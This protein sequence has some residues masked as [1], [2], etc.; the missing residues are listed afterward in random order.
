M[1]SFAN[2]SLATTFFQWM[3]NYNQIATYLTGQNFSTDLA[4]QSTL[5]IATANSVNSVYAYSVANR[6]IAGSAF[7]RAN[8]VYDSSN[9]VSSLATTAYGQANTALAN[10]DAAGLVA[11]GAF[12]AANV[13]QSSVGA[14]Y[15]AANTSQSTAV[16]A[17]GA[18]NTA[19]AT[20]VAA[21]GAAN[22]AQS[23]A[24]AAY[25]AGNT[26][27]ATAVAAY[28]TGNTA[29]ATAVAAFDAANTAG[30]GWEL[31]T[32]LEPTTDVAEIRATGLSGY[33]LIM[34]MGVIQ[35]GTGATSMAV[36]VN[37]AASGGSNRN[38]GAGSSGQLYESAVVW[39][40]IDNF[41]VAD[42]KLKVL[43]GLVTSN[44]AVLDRSSAVAASPSGS[45]YPL[46]GYSS[47]SEILDELALSVSS[48]NVEGSTSNKRTVVRIYGMV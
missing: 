11:V 8:T 5:N 36:N 24:V 31:I 47:Y 10:A 45:Y 15:D 18:G 1:P 16:A 41:N 40:I 27:Q 43:Q 34:F 17:Y 39:G 2:I 37:V 46:S 7:A 9:A 38:I 12:G 29:Q 21:F 42:N 28:G 48:G 20:A 14:A 35:A 6:E 30:G 26:A 3:I 22:V 32:T 13:A 23:T 19:Q 33:S 25:G 44:G 4:D